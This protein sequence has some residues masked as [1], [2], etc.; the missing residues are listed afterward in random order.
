[1]SAVHERVGMPLDEFIEQGNEQP[2]EIING[3]RIPKLPNV[4]GHTYIIHLLYQL[5]FT[6]V[7]LQNLGQ[8]FIEATYAL[9]ERYD[10]NW[11]TGSR[12]PDLM[13]INTERW[14]SYVEANGDWKQKPL[15]IVPDLVI[16]VISPTDKFTD[17]NNKVDLYLLEGVRLVVLVDPQSR[18]AF[19]HAPDAEQPLH[20]SGNAQLDLSEVIPGL[21]VALPA[22]FE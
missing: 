5:L 10:S 8:C 14:T 17:V 13:F 12:I 11:V 16:E 9:P 15:L 3:E 18:K 1:M 4:A 19:V 21:Q 7:T 6:H 2:F 22:L 20:L